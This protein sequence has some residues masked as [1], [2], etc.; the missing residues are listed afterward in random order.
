MQ[1]GTFHSKYVV[2]T[3][4]Y[5]RLQFFNISSDVRCLI[6]PRKKGAGEKFGGLSPPPSPHV[7]TLTKN[8]IVR[9]DY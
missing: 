3:I 6:V 7:S 4:I 2:I 1:A 5:A 9:S 8:K